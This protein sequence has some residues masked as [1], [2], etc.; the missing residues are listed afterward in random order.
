MPSK[1]AAGQL[2]SLVSKIFSDINRWNFNSARSIET[3]ITS[4]G[5]EHLIL[6]AVLIKILSYE[7]K[8]P[9]DLPEIEKN[10]GDIIPYL[11]LLTEIL[12]QKKM[13]S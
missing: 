2:T 13:K 10:K 1:L 12:K 7:I 6:T 9:I 5:L 4:I 11:E 8:L 3:A